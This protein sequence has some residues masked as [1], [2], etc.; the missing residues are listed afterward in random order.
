MEAFGDRISYAVTLNEPNLHRLLD[1]LGL[2]DFVRDLERATLEGA[3]R[4]AGVEHYRAGNVVLPEDHDGMQEGLTAAHR[5]AKAA[6]KAHRDDL[7]S[8]WSIAIVDDCVVGDDP[9][10]RDRKRAELYDHCLDVA[11][12]DDF[13]G[14]QNY[15]RRWYDADGEVDPTPDAPKNE[16]G[17]AVDPAALGGAVR[18]A[19]ERPAC[20]SS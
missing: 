13:I 17:S 1:W 10:V 5:A 7:R 18:Y 19:Y 3:A 14:V 4:A 15:E 20:R 9:S 12:D 11:A 8:G 16:M 6:I 2:P